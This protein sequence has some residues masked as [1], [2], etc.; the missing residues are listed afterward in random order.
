V[1]VV[2]LL[3]VLHADYFNCEDDDEEED[4]LISPSESAPEI[5]NGNP[6]EHDAQGDGAIPR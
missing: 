5:I 3:L 4:D 6:G 2:V 1:L